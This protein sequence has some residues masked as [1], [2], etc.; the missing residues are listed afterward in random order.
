MKG[1]LVATFLLLFLIVSACGTAAPAVTSVPP[2][3]ETL[4]VPI[5]GATETE[6]PVVTEPPV[7]TST[8]PPT[9]TPEPP[10]PTNMPDC[11]NSASF[12][13]DVTIPD[14][15]EMVGDAIFVKTWRIANTG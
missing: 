8:I 9:L 2:T 5:T 1:K 14:N 11:T 13:T 12:V 7:A 6:P 10:R 4:A 15:S 3:A